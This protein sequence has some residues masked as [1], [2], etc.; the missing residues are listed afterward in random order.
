MLKAGSLCKDES[1]WSE[2][3]EFSSLSSNPSFNPRVFDPSRLFKYLQVFGSS[4]T[5]CKL[6]IPLTWPLWHGRGRRFDPDQVH[7]I[8]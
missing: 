1:S 5:C 4:G 8:Y 2:R 3:Q 6:L 7:Q